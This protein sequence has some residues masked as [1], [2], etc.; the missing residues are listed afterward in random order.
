MK[1]L[2]LAWIIACIVWIVWSSGEL[3]AVLLWLKEKRA[4][5]LY[6]LRRRGA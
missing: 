6:W 5:F 1:L 2:L 3:P 4:N